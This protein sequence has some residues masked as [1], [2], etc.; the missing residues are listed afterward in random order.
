VSQPT[1]ARS[2]AVRAWAYNL[3]MERPPGLAVGIAL[4]V[5]SV[6]VSGM[7]EHP[8]VTIGGQGAN[9]TAHDV[10]P[11]DLASGAGLLLGAADALQALSVL[12]DVEHGPSTTNL[13][14]KD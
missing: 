13:S 7:S 9:I 11:E 2:E 5:V 4:D 10:V 8:F 14:D 6:T 12:A 1:T 3:L